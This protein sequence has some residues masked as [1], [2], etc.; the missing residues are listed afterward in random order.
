M[1]IEASYGMLDRGLAA[2]VP[3]FDFVT[4]RFFCFFFVPDDFLTSF[5]AI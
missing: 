1:L 5:L 2:D 3:T 4:L